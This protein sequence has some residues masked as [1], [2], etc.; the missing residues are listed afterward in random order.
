M[1]EIYQSAYEVAVCLTTH[2]FAQTIATRESDEAIECI[3]RV[4]KDVPHL[5]RFLTSVHDSDSRTWG[6]GW[7]DKEEVN[8]QLNI[9][10]KD[11]VKDKDFA[12][13]WLDVLRMRRMPW[14]S[15]AWVT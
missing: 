3:E 11:A 2:D 15:R 9:Y 12:F 5:D 8:C 6:N 13:G 7:G 1:Y 4:Y 14:F 10:L